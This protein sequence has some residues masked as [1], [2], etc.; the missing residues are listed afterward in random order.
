MDSLLGVFLL[1]MQ[2]AFP[3]LEASYSSDGAVFSSGG[4]SVGVK[5]ISGDRVAVVSG[6]GAKEYVFNDV[7][8]VMALATLQAVVLQGLDGDVRI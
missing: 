8:D 4:H 2:K 3:S 6:D 5:E 7:S 1:F